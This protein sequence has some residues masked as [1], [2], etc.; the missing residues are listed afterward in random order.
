MPIYAFPASAVAPQS[1]LVILPP[2]IKTDGDWLVPGIPTVVPGMIVGI[3]PSVPGVILVGY[4]LT[5]NATPPVGGGGPFEVVMALSAGGSPTEVARFKITGGGGP[6]SISDV[7]LAGI[8]PFNVPA[9]G[10][11]VEITL[12]CS[13]SGPIRLRANPT[14]PAFL[15]VIQ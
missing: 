4:N 2:F 3:N 11:P 13:P 7:P 1:G 12:S 8:V 9:G 5:F 10:N 14:Q 6:S 15:S